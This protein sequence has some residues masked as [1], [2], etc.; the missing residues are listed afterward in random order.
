ML[1]GSSIPLRLP[2][3]VT[4]AQARLNLLRLLASAPQIHPALPSVLFR[5]PTLL[6]CSGVFS[7]RQ[8]FHCS[9]IF[10]SKVVF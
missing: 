5:Q 10:V 3:D 8:G 1:L 2:T 9:T 7:N 4:A 6:P